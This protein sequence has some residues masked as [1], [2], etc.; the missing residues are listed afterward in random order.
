MPRH[1]L[2]TVL[3]FL[4][5]GPPMLAGAWIGWQKAAVEYLKRKERAALIDFLREADLARA[6]FNVT[7][8]SG[9][10]PLEPTQSA[11]NLDRE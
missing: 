1:K 7:V 11:E 3:I 4:A 6:A 10:L 2:R 9:G 8:T 5:V